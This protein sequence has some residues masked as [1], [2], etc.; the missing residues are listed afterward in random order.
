MPCQ[1]KNRDDLLDDYLLSRLAG[2]PL[3]EFEAHYFGCA[4]CAEELRLRQR[5][6]AAMKEERGYVT[7]APPKE[8]VVSRWSLRWRYAGVAFATGLAFFFFSRLLK[9]PPEKIDAE[10]FVANGYLESLLEQTWQTS[11]VLITQASPALGENLEGRI[12]FQWQAARAGEKF[13]GPLTLV[14]MNNKNVDVFRRSVSGEQYLFEGSLP[15]GL[16]YWALEEDGT[17]IHLGKFLF[18]KRK[19]S[20]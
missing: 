2:E 16:Y 1:L 14:I 8:R 5:V 7:A 11:E 19:A 20:K 12:L 10:N 15:A 3:E 13:A 4:E 18:G 6:V 17:T 9:T